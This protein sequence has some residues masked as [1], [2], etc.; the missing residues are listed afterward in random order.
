MLNTDTI[1]KSMKEDQIQ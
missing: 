1:E